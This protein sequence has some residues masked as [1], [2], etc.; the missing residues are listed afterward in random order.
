VTPGVIQP[1]LAGVQNAFL[2]KLDPSGNILF[3]TFLGGSGSDSANAL[4][5]DVNGNIYIAGSTNSL[6]F[7]TTPGS[8]EPSPLIPAWS[9]SAG[10][11]IATLT[12]DAKSLTYGSYLWQVAGLALAPSGD[13]YLTGPAGGPGLPITPTAPEPCL[14][15][16]GF[17]M[18][19]A[20]A[21]KL[22][23]AE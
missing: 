4:Q 3:S 12:P 21:V 14:Q 1:Q 8:F 18:H 19:D 10:G 15:T 23:D 7:P 13:V 16:Y 22:G 17:V 9:T 2:T 11:F 20:G 5:I 6:D